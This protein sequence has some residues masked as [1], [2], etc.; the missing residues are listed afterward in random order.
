[1][2]TLRSTKQELATK[3]QNNEVAVNERFLYQRKVIQEVESK[4]KTLVTKER[5]DIMGTELNDIKQS[6]EE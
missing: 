3:I 4:S 2:S 5:F 1:M 6:L